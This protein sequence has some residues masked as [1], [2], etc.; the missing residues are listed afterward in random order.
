MFTKKYVGPV[1]CASCEK[2]IINMSGQPADYHAWK[3]LPFREPSERIARVS[4]RLK[5]TFYLFSTAKGFLK[6]W[7][8]CA[9]VK[10][11][12]KW[13]TTTQP[14]TTDKTSTTPTDQ[15]DTLQ[16]NTAHW[17]RSCMEVLSTT[18]T[19]SWPRVPRWEPEEAIL[20]LKTTQLLPTHLPATKDMVGLPRSC[21]WRRSTVSS[22]CTTWVQPFQT[23]WTHFQMCGEPF[24]QRK[25][26]YTD[27]KVNE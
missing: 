4:N 12:T 22:H 1:N 23:T 24:T 14:W 8:W 13:A 2:G 6:S 16:T 25:Q 17:M 5:L 3:R 15:M 27:I 19:T 10:A 26:T 18:C 20:R 11:T 9:Q 7:P 21:L